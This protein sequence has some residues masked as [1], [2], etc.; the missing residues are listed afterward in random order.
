MAMDFDVMAR[1]ARNISLTSDPAVMAKQKENYEKAREGMF[2]KDL[3]GME[4]L[5]TSEKDKQMFSSLKTNLEEVM[6]FNDKAVGLGLTNHKS[7]ASE[8]IIKH[9]VPSQVKLFE[10]MAA[11]KELEGKQAEEDATKAVKAASGGRSL[12]IV[13]AGFAVAFGVVIAFFLDPHHHE[14]DCQPSC[15]NGQAR[16]RRRGRYR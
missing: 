13:I 4:K 7:E 2:H 5:L 11:F 15:R 12:M 3:A 1:S 8:V 16:P 10:S 9:I 6:A 14:A